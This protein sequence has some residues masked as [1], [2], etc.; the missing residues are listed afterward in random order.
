MLGLFFCKFIAYSI[1]IMLSAFLCR[2]YLNYD[3]VL[4][5]LYII[6][7]LVFK[8]LFSCR[9]NNLLDFFSDYWKAVFRQCFFII[10][11]PKCVLTI[12]IQFRQCH[13]TIVCNSLLTERDRLQEYIK[14]L[15]KTHV[16]YNL[17]SNIKS[18]LRNSLKFD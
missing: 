7:F 4:G 8:Y 2:I 3:E 1:V 11:F 16:I 13:C 17:H 10:Y 14:C 15:Y 18:N 6:K 9:S 5:I 12:I